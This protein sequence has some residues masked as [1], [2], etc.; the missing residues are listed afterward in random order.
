[1]LGNNNVGNNAMKNFDEMTRRR[2]LAGATLAAAAGLLSGLDLDSK[3][4]AAWAKAPMVKKPAPVVS[5][6]RWTRFSM[7][8]PVER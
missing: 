4:G 7:P 5:S 8:H 2:L 3:F 1:M 6:G